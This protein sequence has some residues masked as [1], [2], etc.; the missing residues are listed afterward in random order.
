MIRRPPRSTL[1]PY[2]TLFRSESHWAPAVPATA[3]PTPRLWQRRQRKAGRRVGESCGG[4]PQGRWV[5][6]DE[7][8]SACGKARGGP[9]RRGAGRGEGA[10]GGG[11]RAG[12]GRG[13]EECRSRWRMG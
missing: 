10:G 12:E 9:A 1:F 8:S 3:T 4:V 2:T 5:H 13:G 6:A 11:G 7:R